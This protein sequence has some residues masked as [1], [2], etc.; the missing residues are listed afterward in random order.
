MNDLKELIIV[1]SQVK[2]LAAREQA[3]EEKVSRDSLDK[4]Q[5]IKDLTDEM[6]KL[7]E[8]M[9]DLRDEKV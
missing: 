1:K 5:I 2:D 3:L 4:W 9:N 7:R 6:N 8:E